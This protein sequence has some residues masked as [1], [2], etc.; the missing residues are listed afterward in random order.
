[1]K[2]KKGFSLV[3]VL[4]LVGIIVL[5]LGLGF[6]A[7]RAFFAPD[8]NPAT[9]SASIPASET[10]EVISTKEDLERE[11]RKL[12][13]FDVESSDFYDAEKQADI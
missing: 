10:A 11:S 13:G 6:V 4:V 5:I 8:S 12:D 7:W 9:T 3:E 1:M 2:G